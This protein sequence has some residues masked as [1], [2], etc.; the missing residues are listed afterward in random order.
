MKDYAGFW[1]R[2]GAFA[3]D[4]LL[5]L[6]YL[7]GI[8]VLLMTLNLLFD[9][10]EWLFGDRTRAQLVAFLL[11]TIP[12]ALYFAISESS[13]QQATWGKH[14]LNLRVTDRAGD[15]IRFGRALVRTT[16]KFIPWELSHT[17]IW[18]IS[19][20][21]EATSVWINYG[22]LLVYGLIG[23][24]LVSLLATRRHQTLYDLLAGTYVIG[25]R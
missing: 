25:A 4:Y 20:A 19:F 16:L 17:L 10:N 2:T 1:R 24:N 18:Q 12:V 21:P 11:V 7:L 23:V 6:G 5:I 3:L 14:R 9:I 15:R 8:T 22:F 13:P